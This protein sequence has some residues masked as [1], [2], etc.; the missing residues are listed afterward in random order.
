MAFGQL[1]AL[2]ELV[3][4]GNALAKVQ[5]AAPGS[6][7]SLHRFSLSGTKLI[8]WRDMDTL[9]AH[10]P[11]LTTLRMSQIPL[12][13]GKG[14]SEVR[15]VV[16]ARIPQLG[17]FN[18]SVV[19]LRERTDAERGYLRSILYDRN[20]MAAARSSPAH[21]AADTVAVA[22]A[23]HAELAVVH[24]RYEELTAKYAADMAP[25]SRNAA[26]HSE[27]LASDLVSVTLRN[28]SFGSNGS[29]EPLV[30]KLPKTLTIARLKV[31]VSQ[32]FGLEHRLQQLSM[33]LYK[34]SVPF[35][36][37]DE[38][39]SIEYFGAIDGAEIFINEAKR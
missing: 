10:Y 39:S 38:S 18:G 31:M 26:G 15:P 37:D 27:N 24:P 32:L 14:A 4:D 36:L 16:I 20:A 17:F 7:A 22:A 23:V 21:T 35:V 28:M 9:A 29:L 8:S 12:F 1:P 3:L 25:V 19:S 33:R 34:D 13:L 11:G 2:Q 6:F 30:K 5:P